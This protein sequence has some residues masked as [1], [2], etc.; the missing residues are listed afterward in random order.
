MILVMFLQVCHQVYDESLPTQLGLYH[1]W[2][3]V[4]KICQQQQYFTYVT[5]CR[6]HIPITTHLTKCE[7]VYD[8][9]FKLLAGGWL[10]RVH[11]MQNTHQSIHNHIL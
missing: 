2:V 11:P 5:D 1:P 3:Y 4:T 6:P 7:Y 10:I 8:V 9:R